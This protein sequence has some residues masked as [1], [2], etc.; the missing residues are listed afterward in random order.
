MKFIKTALI[1]MMLFIA[2][3]GMVHAQSNN[4]VVLMKTSMGDIEIEL[5][6][7]KAP[8]TVTNFLMYVD[9]SFYNGTIFHRVIGNFMIQGGGFTPGMKEKTTSSPIKNE[10]ANG[11]PNTIGTIAMAR[12]RDV[13]SATAQFF[14]NVS[15]NRF[16]DY[17][18]S[19]NDGY[20]YCVFGTVIKGMDVVEKIRKVQTGNSGPFQDVPV[21]DVIINKISRK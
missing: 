6:K 11:I 19:T 4:V 15:N 16:L 9:K 13:H 21:Q 8:L 14:I 1:I 20:G 17:K 2:S 5:F 3:S 7:D 12:T 10:A 18:S